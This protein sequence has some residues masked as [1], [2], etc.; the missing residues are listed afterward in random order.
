MPIAPNVTCLTRFASRDDDGTEK[1]TL[2]VDGAVDEAS[3]ADDESTD[4]NDTAAALTSDALHE[5]RV[6]R[7]GEGF[8]RSLFSIQ[9]NQTHRASKSLLFVQLRH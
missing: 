2:C 8:A 9:K 4:F 6:D 3:D 5:V 7:G 1:R